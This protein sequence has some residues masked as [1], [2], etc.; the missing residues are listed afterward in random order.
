M[1]TEINHQITLAVRPDG[2]PNESDF[3]QVESPV[4]QPGEG[5]VI[6]RAIWLSLDPYQRGRMRDAQSSSL[7]A[8]PFQMG[9]VE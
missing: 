1:S 6:V 8:T 9:R 2:Y 7:Y 3:K 4:P 5:E